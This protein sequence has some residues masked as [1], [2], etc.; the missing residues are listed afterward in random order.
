MCW[1]TQPER[2][3]WGRKQFM[4]FSLGGIATLGRKPIGVF[5]NFCHHGAFVP[6]RDNF[7]FNRFNIAETFL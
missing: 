3:P 7:P 5:S 4:F 1:E 6:K 2:L